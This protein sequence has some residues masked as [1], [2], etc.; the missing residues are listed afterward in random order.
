MN[1]R[2]LKSRMTLYG[3]TQLSLANYLRLSTTRLNM[4]INETDGAEFTASEI[5]DIVRRYELT[6]DEINEIFFTV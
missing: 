6:A 3:D 2:L 5:S 4:K 1:T